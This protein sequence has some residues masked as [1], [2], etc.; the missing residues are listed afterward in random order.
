VKEADGDGSQV[1]M[2]MTLP[3]ERT[4]PRM[5]AS[6]TEHSYVRLEGLLPVGA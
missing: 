5:L 3:D 2:H 1:T 4:R 6:A